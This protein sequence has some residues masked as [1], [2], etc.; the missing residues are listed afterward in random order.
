MTSIHHR[1]MSSNELNHC[2]GAQVRLSWLK[3]L[4][5]S[6]CENQLWEFAAQA[7]LLH[8]VVCTI[9]ADKSTTFVRVR[10]CNCLEI[11]LYVIDMLLELLLLSTFMNT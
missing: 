1:A 4:Y 11:F 8:L 3:D 5:T 2:R 7:Y 6:Y 10:T 9:F